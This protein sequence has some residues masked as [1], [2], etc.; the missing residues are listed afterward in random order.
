MI[1]DRAM[2]P[3][4]ER[5]N[6][7]MQP[8]TPRHHIDHS[9]FFFSLSIVHFGLFLILV[10]HRREGRPDSSPRPRFKILILE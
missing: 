1:D 8:H 5:M 4:L 3:M 10:A 6:Y 9:R 2:Q 7:E